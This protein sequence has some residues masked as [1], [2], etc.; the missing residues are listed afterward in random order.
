MDKDFNLAAAKAAVKAAYK[1]YELAT[2]Y[3]YAVN[4]QATDALE[5]LVAAIANNNP[6]VDNFK[7]A[8]ESAKYRADAAW[9]EYTVARDSAAETEAIYK[10]AAELN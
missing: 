1:K 5:A 7:G 8:Y 2:K 4:G 9:D 3:A 6:Y 10:A